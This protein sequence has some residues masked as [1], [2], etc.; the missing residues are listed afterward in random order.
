[1]MIRIGAIDDRFSVQR[2]GDRDLNRLRTALQRW[3][4]MEDGV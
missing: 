1:M 4:P 3:F 2:C